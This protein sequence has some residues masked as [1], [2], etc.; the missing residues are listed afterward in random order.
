M[1]SKEHLSKVDENL[2]R[3]ERTYQPGMR[4]PGYVYASEKLIELALKDNALSQVANVATLPGIVSA[5]LA[6]PD[7]HWG[8]GFV[9]GGVAAFD[10]KRGGI[11]SPG[12][13][14]YDINCG[15]RLIRSNLDAVECAEQITPLVNQIFRDVPVGV[16]Q[17]GDIVFEGKKM[18][19]LLKEGAAAVVREGLSWE[20]DLEFIEEGGAL[21]G[22]DP[23]LVTDKAVKRG[24]RQCGT[25]GAG[26]H[27]IEIQRVEEIFDP[28]AAAAYG[29]AVGMITV[30][31]HTGSRGLGH[32]TCEDTLQV[33]RNAVTKYEIS[34]PDRQLA[35][36]PLESREGRDYLAA[37][38]CAANF[39]W[40]NRSIITNF[41]RNGFERV[42]GESAERLGLEIVYDVAHNIAKWETHTVDNK[43]IKLLVHRKGATRAFPAGHPDIPSKYAH[44]GQPV[45][46]PGDMGTASWV[47]RAQPKAMEQTF[48]ST[49]HGA[50]RAMGRN[51]A[52]RQVNY[53]KLMQDMERKGIVVR[54]GSKSGLVEEAPEAYKDVDEVV[55]VTHQS[56]ISTKVARM[57]PLAVI[58]G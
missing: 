2:Y 5:S 37:M 13:V 53:G 10:P 4:V 33:M 45:I 25:L 43:K 9:I 24:R 57:I 28:E 19:R 49:C 41:V 6:M 52:K 56:G 50:G 11:V 22:A 17:G 39:A 34:L 38:A 21:D 42:L 29:L 36:A 48:G 7:I 23:S 20:D 8:Y 51:E 15:V 14:G 44:I 18:E 32:Q 31:I 40:A 26:N 54:A 55:E 30:M 3:M 47:L 16:G 12:G 1:A 27:F 35:C 46:I 58:K